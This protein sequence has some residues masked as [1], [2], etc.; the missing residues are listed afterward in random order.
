MELLL[1]WDLSGLPEKE[2]RL[3]SISLPGIK[4]PATIAFYCHHHRNFFTQKGLT[5]ALFSIVFLP[6][7]NLL[8]LESPVGVGF[9]YTNTSSDLTKL[10]DTFVGNLTIP[11]VSLCF[12]NT[13]S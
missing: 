13:V 1:K 12:F 3:S 9:S 7:A 2:Q 5:V 8:F 11:L 6:E 10:D 4:V